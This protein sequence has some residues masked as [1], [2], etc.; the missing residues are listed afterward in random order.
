M[1]SIDYVI[2]KFEKEHP[3]DIE[4]GKER[5]NC[6]LVASDFSRFAKKF[7]LDVSRIFG[8]FTLDGP[9]TDLE[10][11]T[12][13]EIGEMEEEGLNPYDDDDRIS[14]IVNHGLGDEFSKVPH[15]WN[16][17][18]GRI[19]DFSGYAQFV[20]T[21]LADDTDA[22]RYEPKSLENAS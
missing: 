20:E 2:K 8:T 4:C 17:Y 6:G 13:Y 12:K 21:G 15:Y 19:I 22:W 3:D 5:G 9:E 14:F 10:A 16:L 7:G 18:N 1:N 11:F